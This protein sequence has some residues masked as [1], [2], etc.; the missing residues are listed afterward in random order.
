LLSLAAVF[1][2]SGIS[3]LYD[4]Q[5]F[6]WNIMDVG[7]QNMFV[8]GI[9]ARLF[10]SFELLLGAALALHLYLKAFTYPAV[11]ALLFFFS[12]Y[13]VFLIATQGDGGNCGCFGEAY[14][15]K[16]SAGIV[17]NIIL[18]GITALLWVIYPIKPYKHSE[19][20][21][22]SVGMI[23]LALPF[24]FFPLS[25]DRKPD[26]VY[27]PIRLDALYAQTPSPNVELR[28]G[29]HIVAFMSLSCPHCKK[30][31][32]LFHVIKKQHPEFPIYLILHGS[33]EYKK[34]FFDETKAQDV[35]HF[36]FYNTE[37]FTRYAEKGVPAI[38]FI[39]NSVIERE[40]NYYQISPEI[41]EEWLR[42]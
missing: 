26:V 35:P 4:F 24:I 28:K 34:D 37:A 3:K 38:Y 17:K 39:N 15:M 19:W 36:R 11:I 41:I 18:L 5:R 42:K 10:I 16:P 23:A 6:I 40:A 25:T 33:D 12:V 8:A 31:A 1:L 2:F 27:V 21:T 13:L 20:L 29:K 30:A 32:F 7:I 22:L 9:L 14:A